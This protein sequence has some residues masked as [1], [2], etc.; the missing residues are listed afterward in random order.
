MRRREVVQ[1][2]EAARLAAR[3]QQVEAE[4]DALAPRVDALER[5]LA[6]AKAEAARQADAA[7][8]VAEEGAPVKRELEAAQQ[9]IASLTWMLRQREVEAQRQATSTETDETLRGLASSPG[10]EL[11]SLRAVPPFQDVRGH[12]LWRPGDD[13]LRLYAFDL[14]PLPEGGSYRVRVGMNGGELETGPAFKPSG[15]GS[16][17]L[18]IRLR[19]PATRL[20]AVEILI[21]PGA[22]PVLSGK[23]A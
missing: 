9:R 16:V 2:T 7:R 13:V 22:E 14:P 23:S 21:E 3:L 19:A 17:E 6:A 8:I 5:D 11:L 1:R 15:H 18:S 12:V 10:L 20:R 4:R